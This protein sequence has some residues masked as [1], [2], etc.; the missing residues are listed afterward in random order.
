VADPDELTAADTH[1]PH[2]LRNMTPRQRAMFATIGASLL[3]LLL[4][5]AF[6]VAIL[7]LKRQ[8]TE[9]NGIK[10]LQKDL[11]AELVILQTNTGLPAQRAQAEAINK[12]V[13]CLY[14]YIDYTAGKAKLDPACVSPIVEVPTTPGQPPAVVTPGPG[15]R[16]ATGPPG[17]KGATG[18]T[19]PTG[20]KG[21]TGAA[22]DKG[23]DGSIGPI[24]PAGA[25]GL[26]GPPGPPGPPGKPATPFTFTFTTT[27][28]GPN[29]WTCVIIS[30]AANTLCTA[31]R[32]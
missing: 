11:Q 3:L 29:T 17:P 13:T 32:G 7:L 10:R 12:S 15:V 23:A 30:P 6:Y 9:L 25:T 27:R 4:F 16:G 8:S 2:P 14:N 21:D 19:G 31:L 28:G 26:A 5:A 22:G 20:P 18:P 1:L 24:G